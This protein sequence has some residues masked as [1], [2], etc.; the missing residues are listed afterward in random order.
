MK[1]TALFL[2]ALLAAPVAAFAHGDGTGVPGAEFLKEWDMS[3]TGNVT[4]ADMQTR[5]AEIFEMFD[6]NGDGH[7]DA[8]EAENMAQTVAGQQE[9]NAASRADQAG[10]GQGQGQGQ[11]QGKGMGQGN[12]QGRGQ[13]QGNGQ[14]KGQNQASAGGQGGNG[15]GQIIHAAMTVAFNDTDGNGLVTR[16]EFVNASAQIFATLDRNA[17]A[18]LTLEDFAR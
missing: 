8:V 9:N 15:P 4:L 16:Q 17:D 12:G 5:R 1:T 18:A 10:N 3:G 13:G 7:I 11:G 14:G 6:L 2:A